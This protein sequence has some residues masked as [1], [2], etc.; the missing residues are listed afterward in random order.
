MIFIYLFQ[1]AYINK[2]KDVINSTWTQSSHTIKD[3]FPSNGCS[4]L[5]EISHSGVI[6]SDCITTKCVQDTKKLTDTFSNSSE[7][8]LTKPSPIGGFRQTDERTK[9][10]VM[11]TIITDMEQSV[12]GM[13]SFAKSLPKFYGLPKDDQASLLKGIVC[14]MKLENVQIL[15]YRPF[16]VHC[17]LLF[18][19]MQTHSV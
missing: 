11:S 17:S 18:S 9:A 1:N 5:T 8:N 7:S 16:Q 10:E 6:N 19:K 2:N 13:L 15:T 4:N 3:N 14:I 12:Q